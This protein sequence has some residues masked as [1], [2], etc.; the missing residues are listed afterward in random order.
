M[1]TI[2]IVMPV[3]NEKNTIEEIIRRVKSV[4]LTKEIIIVDDGSTDGTRNILKHINDDEIKVVFKD[5]NEGKGAA[6]R[7]GFVHVTGGIVIIQDADLEYNPDEY[8]TLIKPIEDGHADVVFGSR[9]LSTGTHRV[10]FFWHMIG[11]KFLTL[12]TNMVCN[13]NLSDLETCYKAFRSDVIKN[14]NLEEKRFGFEPEVTIKVSQMDC[15]IYEVGISYY[16]RKYNAGKKIGWKDGFEAIRCIFKY[17]IV[18][19][20]FDGEPLLE[21]I[22][23]RLRLKKVMPY[24]ENGQRIC[25][26]GCGCHFALLRNISNVSKECIGIDKK[27]SSLSY[28]NINVKQIFLNDSLPLADESVDIVTMLA[29]LE[30]FENEEEILKEVF[31]ILRPLGSLLLTVPSKKARWLI[32][33]LTYGFGLLSKAEIRD[34]KRYHTEKTLKDVLSKVG[35]RDIKVS[36]FQLGCNIFGVIKK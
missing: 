18:K 26:I 24:I 17:G 28:S 35:F 21:K 32:N 33:I 4:P 13:L 8:F 15:R 34:H 19:K 5:K 14:I 31:R 10:L 16:G 2:S 29:T 12:L 23:R 11:N 3:Y 9:F 22:L 25:D 30:H 20:I 7:T 6:L 36:S 1:T 27:V